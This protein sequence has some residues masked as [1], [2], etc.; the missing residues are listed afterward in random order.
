MTWGWMRSMPA[1]WMARAASTPSN[2]PRSPRMTLPPPPSSAGVPITSRRPPAAATTVAAARAAPRPAA[3]MMLCPQ[4]CPMPGRA[5]YSHSTAIRGPSPPSPSSA[6]W[7]TKAVSSPCAPRS[8]TN[9]SALQGGG[10]QVGREP[11]LEQQLRPLMDAMGDVEQQRG[12]LVDRG[13]HPLP[14]RCRGRS[15]EDHEPPRLGV[16]RGQAV[17]DGAA[18][19]VEP[20]GTSGR[21]PRRS[22][23]EL[24]GDVVD[25]ALELALGLVELALGLAARRCR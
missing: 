8:T 9:P 5:S 12:P 21:A 10:Q 17:G 11:L 19:G 6:G 25:E 16:G 4:P 23:L 3:A 14:G 7:P 15:E 20:S 2:A 22:A 13:D 24:V 18:E 1:G